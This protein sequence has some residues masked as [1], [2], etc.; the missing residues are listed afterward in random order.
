MVHASRPEAVSTVQSSR[1]S[2][3]IHDAANPQHTDSHDADHESMPDQIPLQKRLRQTDLTSG[4]AAHSFGSRVSTVW[5]SRSRRLMQES[6]AA[7]EPTDSSSTDSINSTVPPPPPPGPPRL[8]DSAQRPTQEVSPSRSSA[9]VPAANV[10]IVETA[11]EFFL[12]TLAGVL[13][14]CRL[15]RLWPIWRWKA[16]N[17]VDQRMYAYK[18]LLPIVFAVFNFHSLGVQAPLV[19]LLLPYSIKELFRGPSARRNFPLG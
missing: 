15:S 6:D 11:T 7:P 8:F 18:Y 2:T 5:L 14:E 9:P 17:P 3:D 4:D 16:P 1:I 12:A 10:T 19:A 13:H